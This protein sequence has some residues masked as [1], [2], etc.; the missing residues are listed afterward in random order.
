MED[1]YALGPRLLQEAG[2]FTEGR[3]GTVCAICQYVHCIASSG[4]V[5]G[6]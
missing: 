1:L 5:T 3:V 6:E 2:L 4:R